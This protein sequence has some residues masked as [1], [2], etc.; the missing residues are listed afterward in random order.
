MKR[1]YEPVLPLPNPGDWCDVRQAVEIIGCSRAYLFQMMALGKLP[2]YKI[3]GVRLLW[4]AHV[5]AFAAA[6]KMTRRGVTTDA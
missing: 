4:R 3:G 1:T 5:D 2:G 6:W